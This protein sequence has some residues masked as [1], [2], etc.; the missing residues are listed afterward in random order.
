MLHYRPP[1]NQGEIIYFSQQ[2]IVVSTLSKI[3][4]EMCTAAGITGRKMDHSGEVTCTT[5]LYQK[6]FSDQQIK[7]RTGHRS[8]GGIVQI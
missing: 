5:T 1:P 7:E 2:P 6:N 3:V 4:P 8:N